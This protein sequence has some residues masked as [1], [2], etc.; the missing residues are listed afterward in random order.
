MVDCSF[1]DERLEAIT[2]DSEVINRLQAG[3]QMCIYPEE[4]YHSFR[5]RYTLFKF[6]PHVA[7]YAAVAKVPI[8]PIAVIGAEEAAPTLFGLKKAAVPLHIPFHPPLILPVK[9]TLVIGKPIAVDVSD[10]LNAGADSADAG[11][12]AAAE[13][14]RQSLFEMI[15]HYRNCSLKDEKYIERSSW[16]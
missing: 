16:F 3:E 5:E 12:E 2:A 11:Y 10:Q 9:I 1:L 6:S 15:G 4:S 14:I 8:I 13:Q 7:K